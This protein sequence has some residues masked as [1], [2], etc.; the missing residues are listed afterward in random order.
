[1]G[2]VQSG[3]QNEQE[4][5]RRKIIDDI[6]A[7]FTEEPSDEDAQTSL[8]EASISA[9]EAVAIRAEIRE[10]MRQKY[11]E[12]RAA[13]RSKLGLQEK[14]FSKSG[15]AAKDDPVIDLAAHSV[16]LSSTSQPQAIAGS[17]ISIASTV[18]H[19]E[20]SGNANEFCKM[21]RTKNAL[22]HHRPRP[23]QLLRGNQKSLRASLLEALRMP[24]HGCP[25]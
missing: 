6:I 17:D 12:G 22:P 18:S 14:G 11:A 5:K 3:H 1:M 16:N 9:S 8:G 2:N 13:L 4:K 7:E 20:N 23:L 15:T 24:I 21:S 19:S 25:W 10:I